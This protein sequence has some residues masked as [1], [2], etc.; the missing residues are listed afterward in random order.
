MKF[1]TTS[2]QKKELFPNHKSTAQLVS[3]EDNNWIVYDTINQRLSLDF[4]IENL[5][6]THVVSLLRG[7]KTHKLKSNDLTFF[8]LNHA[9]KMILAYLT[10]K[11]AFKEIY[12]IRYYT[13]LH[14]LGKY[15]WIR[16]SIESSV[17][18][19]TRIIGA[20]DHSGISQIAFSA[21]RRMGIDTVY[22]QHASVGNS[23]PPLHTTLALLDGQDAKNK[24]ALAGPSDTQV[25]LVGSS[26]YDK[27]ISNPSISKLGSMIAICVGH[28]DTNHEDFKTLC[29]EL[30][31]ANEPFC[32]RFHPAV[33][34]E[35]REAY[36][37]HG[38]NLS[39]PENESALD[40]IIKCHTII[41]A[42]SNILL[43][44]ILLHRRPI[45]LSHSRRI[46]DYYGFVENGVVETV[47][48]TWTDVM[49]LLEK[50]FDKEK[51]RRAAKHY[52]DTLYT[53]FEGR[54]GELMM[55]VLKNT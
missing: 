32:I 1:F 43:E 45:Y 41:S 9:K 42:D 8:G 18:K 30:D 50:P 39:Q 31:K 54:S 55:E 35:T 16:K 25:H 11:K 53:D 17:V 26:K 44:A 23:F 51:H 34:K 12:A 6:S 36:E 48:Y 28:V 5:E 3:S 7:E 10:Y 38:W 22:L 21:A 46:F 14:I 47:N 2:T 37:S 4:L 27:Y 24:Y 20:N 40:L 19:P 13:L 49:T 29:R 33:D 52:Q 15:E